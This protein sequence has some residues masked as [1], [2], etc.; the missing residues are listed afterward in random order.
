M[1]PYALLAIAIVAE[2]I[3]TSAMRASDGFTRVLPS[4]L[5]VAGYGVAFY[6]LSLTLKSIPVGV[7]YAVWS[8]AGIVLIT[9]VAL[10][11]YRQVPDLPA[12][13]GLGLIVAG[14]AVLNLFSKMQA[15]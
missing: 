15:H 12:I 2:V 7:V 6:C 4:A 3:A 11:L 8:G 5:V 10:V 1:P 13:I 9:L 14:V